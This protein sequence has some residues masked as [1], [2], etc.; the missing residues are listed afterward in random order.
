MNSI[1]CQDFFQG[2]V[3]SQKRGE[4]RGITSI[5]SAHPR[6]I[7]A[8]MTQARDDGLPLLIE[9]T[10][11]QVNQFGG[12]TGMWPLGF[13]D[14]VCESADRTGFPRGR[15]IFGGDHLGPYPWRNEPAE[16][17]MQK[18]C[19]LIAHCVRAGYAKIH[20]DASM[21][22]GGDSLDDTGG[23]DAQL[24]ASRTARMAAAAEGAF[25]ESSRPGGT[26]AA[27]PPLYVI[28]TDVP[29][30]G[31]IQAE[32]QAVPITE[33]Q[34]YERTIAACNQAFADAGLQD[35]WQRVFAVVVQPGVEFGD[36]VV[37][38]YDRAKAKALIDAAR[39]HPDLILEG[40]STDYQRPELLRQLVEDGVAVL[41]VGPALTFALRECLFALECIEKEIFGW[42]YK[43]RLSQLGMFLDKAM[44]DNPVHWQN[45][46]QGSPQDV[47][48]A[49]KYSLSDRSR[50]YWQ[51]PM[52]REAV[53]FLIR[54]LK[55]ADIPLTLISQYLPRHYPEIR[56]GRLT[57]D[58]EDLIHASIRMVLRDYSGA[59]C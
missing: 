28:G 46:Y 36:H 18:A 44:R 51:V 54:N 50:Y 4:P 21:P 26:A 52:V 30:P 48:L 49:L 31:G 57:A 35:A 3:D 41:K 6:V 47:Y 58:P 38:E 2:L 17:A 20:L 1:N 11:N 23:L 33:A 12:Y 39:R 56:E 59:V 5:C 27:S 32:E 25:G 29:P 24:V 43:A 42:T 40:H 53:D 37:F 14:Y 22:L 7:V 16:Q 55:Q 9:S 13:R 34:D 10:V 8:A 19:D 45:Y 15:I